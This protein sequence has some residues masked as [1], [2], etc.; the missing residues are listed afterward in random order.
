MKIIYVDMDGVL[1]DFDTGVERFT[2]V[3]LNHDTQSRELR[4]K[5]MQQVGE[6]GGTQFWVNLCW[7]KDGKFLWEQINTIAQLYGADV[8][9]LSSP[10]TKRGTHFVQNAKKGKPQW[11]RRELGPNVKL[12]LESDKKKYAKAGTILIDDYT[13][14][15]KNFV[16]AGGDAILHKSVFKTVVEL[17]KKMAHLNQEKDK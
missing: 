16:K 5:I 12:I 15:T 7:M 2:G 8:A 9:I 1:V 6:E 13:K 14:N 17:T 3:R 11:V 10:G 4:D